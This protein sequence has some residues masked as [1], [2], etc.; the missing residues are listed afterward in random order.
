MTK[1]ELRSAMPKT[2]AFM[3]LLRSVFGNAE[4]IEMQRAGLASGEFWAIENGHVI[5]V[6]ACHVKRAVRPIFDSNPGTEGYRGPDIKRK[7]KR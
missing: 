1:A 3:D 2:A 4:I 5:G 7:G 6:P